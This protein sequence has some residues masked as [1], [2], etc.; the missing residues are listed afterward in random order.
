MPSPTLCFPRARED[1]RSRLAHSAGLRSGRPVLPA[2]T[3]LYSTAARPRRSGPPFL[4][5]FWRHA[6]ALHSKKDLLPRRDEGWVARSLA[7]NETSSVLRGDSRR[8]VTALS[9]SRTLLGS[10]SCKRHGVLCRYMTP[11]LSADKHRARSK[12]FVHMYASKISADSFRVTSVIKTSHKKASG[13]VCRLSF[14]SRVPV[15]RHTRNPLIADL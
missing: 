13:N 14:V 15:K 2:T 3:P 5:P 4:L 1:R 11:G 10:T 12:P 7:P 8:T 9:Q 6:A